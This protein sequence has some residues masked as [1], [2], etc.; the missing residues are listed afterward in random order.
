MYL[1]ATSYCRYSITNHISYSWSASTLGRLGQRCSIPFRISRGSTVSFVRLHG[2][3][4]RYKDDSDEYRRPGRGSKIYIW[5]LIALNASVFLAWNASRNKPQLHLLLR[6]KFLISV[7]RIKLSRYYTLLTS[8]ISHQEP[9]HLLSNMY[10][11]HLF[12]TILWQC[13]GLKLGHFVILTV[14]SGIAGSAAY[15]TEKL[16]QGSYQAALGASGMVMGMGAAA[17]LL[18]PRQPMLFMGVIPMPLWTIV[19]G[20]AAFDAYYLNSKSS[21]AHSGHLGGL[22]FGSAYYFLS[23]YRFGGIGRLFKIKF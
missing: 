5:S 20:Y 18:V 3:S 13:P 1:N 23:L 16:T 21:V 8:T 17:S 14:G 7:D 2:S 15:V 10:T 6:E 12:S 22:V 9:F 4:K 19:A 11:L